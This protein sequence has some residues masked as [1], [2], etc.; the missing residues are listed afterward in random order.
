MK[1]E[2]KKLSEL[3][4]IMIPFPQVLRN[5]PVRRKRDPHQIPEVDALIQKILGKLGERGRILVRPSGTE[6]LIRVMVEGENEKE[7]LTYAEEI[8]ECIRKKMEE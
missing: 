2:E 3:A 7:I 6:N 8:S 1:R 4:S 5:V